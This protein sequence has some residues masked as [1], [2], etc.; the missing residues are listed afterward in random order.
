[1]MRGL[2]ERL[3]IKPTFSTA[4]H[5]QTDGQTERT[6][7][8]VEHYLR[9]FCNH[10]QS[11]WTTHIPL[12][13]FVYNNTHHSSIGMSP[14]YANY[15]HNP[16]FTNLPSKQQASPAAEG[17]A[18][19]LAEVQEE[20]KATMKTAQERMTRFYDENHGATPKINIGD[21]VWLEATNINTDR[22]SRKLSA[23]RLGPF[24]VKEAISTHAYRLELPPTMKVHDVCH[25]SLLTPHRADT[26]PGR[27]FDEPPPVVVDG[28][29]E[30]IAQEI[31]NSRYYRNR[32]QYLVHWE[33][34][35]DGE[36]T[37]EP[38]SHLD[39]AHELIE[40]FHARHSEAALPTHRPQGPC[41]RGRA[42][43]RA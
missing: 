11:D 39:N 18:D 17:V 35:D 40:E 21:K 1:M 31:K 34:Y 15:G 5:P 29:E 41:R 16:T 8:A 2:Y 19:R 14:F 24:K 42:P 3:G 38:V 30:Y 20:L 25:I 12:A 6:N 10:R 4:Y 7:V 23:R 13:E 22:P 36:E 33:G 27:Q 32:L 28:E 26:I 9:V 37:W 43:P